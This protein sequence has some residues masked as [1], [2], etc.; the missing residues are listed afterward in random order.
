[1]MGPKRIYLAAPIFRPEQLEVVEMLKES[2]EIFR[3]E[4]FSPYHNG[5]DI[6]QGRKPADCSPEE[7]A[8]VLEDNIRHIDWCQVLFAWVGGMGGFTDPG[9]VW[10]MG[11]AHCAHK[12]T[13]AYID[14]KLDTDRQSMNLMLAGTV[15]CVVR[16]RD[17]VAPVMSGLHGETYSTLRAA[18]PPSVLGEELDPVV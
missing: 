12:L 7:R 9:V 1:M 3:H 17:D 6:W 14:E 13:I 11:Y 15:D 16:H 2:A 5:V 4:V 10:E 8:R 18:F